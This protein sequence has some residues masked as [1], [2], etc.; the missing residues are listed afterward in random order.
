TRVQTYATQGMLPVDLEDMMLKEANELSLRARDIEALSPMDPLVAQLRNKAGELIATGRALRTRQALQTKKPT[1]GMLDDLIAQGAVE[2]R[3][4]GPIKNLG[5]RRD[6]RV[7]HMQG[8][9]VWNLTT[10][11]PEVLWYAHFHYSK[12]AP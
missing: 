10:A 11:P 3:K 9:E 6:G 12:A 5:K 8:Y 4:P 1:D 7:D 2:V